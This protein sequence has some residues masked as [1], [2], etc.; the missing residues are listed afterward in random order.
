MY[1]GPYDSSSAPWA[2]SCSIE[3]S[4]SSPSPS[5]IR[6]PYTDML[7]SDWT[8]LSG[9]PSS[10]AP[11]AAYILPPRATYLGSLEMSGV[12]SAISFPVPLGTSPLFSL[13][14]IRRSWANDLAGMYSSGIDFRRKTTWLDVVGHC[15]F[16]DGKDSRLR[17]AWP[18]DIIREAP[19]SLEAPDL[20]PRVLLGPRGG[21]F[22]RSM[23]AM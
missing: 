2:S 10:T 14:N 22:C 8:L 7:P 6:E 23:S 1:P 9:N 17:D 20:P 16:M 12:L 11:P 4:C 15:Y 21:A 18:A 19:W 5:F 3:D 13:A